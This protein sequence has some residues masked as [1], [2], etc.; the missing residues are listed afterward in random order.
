MSINDIIEWLGS[1]GDI[2]IADR[3][4]FIADMRDAFNEPDTEGNFLAEVN[5]LGSRLGDKY[6]GKG[7]CNH[8]LIIATDGEKS[9]SVWS[10]S[11]SGISEAY[12]TMALTDEDYAKVM[13]NVAQNLFIEQINDKFSHDTD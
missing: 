8:L 12:T 10:G 9:T 2:V 13:H 3:D 11:I 5:A 1:R 4:K 6:T 7:K